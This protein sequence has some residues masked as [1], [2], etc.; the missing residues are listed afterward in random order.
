MKWTNQTER[1][2][3]TIIPVIKEEVIAIGRLAVNIV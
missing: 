3:E 2:G 1:L